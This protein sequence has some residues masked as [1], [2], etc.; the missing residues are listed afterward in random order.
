M[1]SHTVLNRYPELKEFLLIIRHE[2]QQ[3]QRPAEEVI[4]TDED[5]IRILKISKRTLN[6]MKANREIPFHQPRVHSSCYYLLAD[7]LHWIS[8]ARFES[9]ANLRKF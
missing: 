8:N 9:L 4:L 2:I 7:I 3:A 5:V 1:N 6:Y